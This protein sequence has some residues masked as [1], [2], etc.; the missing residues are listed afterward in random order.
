M[1]QMGRWYPRQRAAHPRRVIPFPH[2]SSVHP[3]SVGTVTNVLGTHSHLLLASQV[4]TIAIPAPEEFGAPL[5]LCLKYIPPTLVVCS[6]KC[7]C[8]LGHSHLCGWVRAS[9]GLSRPHVGT[10]RTSDCLTPIRGNIQ[11]SQWA[12]QTLHCLVGSVARWGRAPA[13]LA[14]SLGS[15]TL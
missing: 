2:T 10:S 8:Q 12:F 6:A 7:G 3:P 13:Y 11:I 14:V 15:R 1:Q 4:C 9:L 5:C